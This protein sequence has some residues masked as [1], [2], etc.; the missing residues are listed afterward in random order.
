MNLSILRGIIPSDDPLLDSIAPEIRKTLTFLPPFPKRRAAPQTGLRL[1]QSARRNLLEIWPDF[2]YESGSFSYAIFRRRVHVVTT[3]DVVREVFVDKAAVFH[4]KSRQ[5]RRALSPLVGD[6]LIV[7]DG[8]TWRARR[9]IVA[10]VTHVSRLPLL[11]PIMTK[12]VAETAESWSK[13]PSGTEV[14]LLEE[15]GCLT[16]RIIIAAIFGPSVPVAAADAIV[17]A[18]SIYQ[19]LI[20]QVEIVAFLGLPDRLPRWPNLR[21]N[22][23]AR[24]IRREIDGL[25]DVVLAGG[26]T[27]SSLIQAMASEAGSDRSAIDRTACRNEA[28]VMFLAGH[29][30]T[31]NTL[32]WAF[33][34]L[35]QDAE[36]ERRLHD[37]VDAVL[38]G[39]ARFEDLDRLPFVRAVIQE[40]LR[41]YPPVPMQARTAS[42][43]AAIGA[44]PVRAG[45]LVMLNAWVLHRHRKVWTDPDAFVPDRFMPGGSGAPSRYAYVPFG[46]GPR[47]CTGAQFGQT[48][49]IICLATLARRFRLRL[50]P[51]WTVEAVCRLSL[52]PG[53]R[54]PMIVEP[55][56]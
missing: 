22:W 37:E 42:E 30:T 27:R 54:L 2:T 15:M 12:G 51:G 6:G 17:K 8:E 33:F 23:A 46:I 53:T 16:A 14:D 26:E 43:D 19:R 9:P 21:A 28:A 35:S 55:R 25:L 11:A 48:E 56:A 10:P 47:V 49:A 44:T 13:L 45:D 24:R 50:K 29:E 3:P 32:A 20:N 39:P 38:D 40:T 18:F 41:L 7:S 34:I 36:S 1:I 4:A 5:Q 52:R 31:A